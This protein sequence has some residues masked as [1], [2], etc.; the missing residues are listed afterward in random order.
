[1]AEGFPPGLAADDSVALRFEGTE[2]VEAI[3]V[4]SGARAYRVTPSGEEPIE[5]R[6][7]LSGP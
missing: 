6:L 7:L 5:P 4:R 3:S 2:L 1:V